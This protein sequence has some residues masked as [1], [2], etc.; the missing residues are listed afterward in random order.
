MRASAAPRREA[1]LRGPPPHGRGFEAR[2][3]TPALRRSSFLCSYEA[4]FRNR[5]AVAPPQ[6]LDQQLSAPVKPRSHGPDRHVQHHGG[7]RVVEF[8]QVT[9]D[10]D[11]AVP[12]RQSAQASAQMARFLVRGQ[13]R[14]RVLATDSLLDLIQRD[15]APQTPGL[16]PREIARDARTDTFSAPRG[17]RRT[18]QDLASAR[19]TPPGRCP[20]RAPAIRSWPGQIDTRTPDGGG[21]GSQR[22]PARLRARVRP[23]PGR[24]AQERLRRA[25]W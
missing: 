21:T 4:P 14:G 15:E 5:Q 18:G 23:A 6:T 24:T 3:A 9:E 1:A 19:E 16:V 10:D 22:L 20:P 25:P 17:W 7:L 11:L 8:L 2:A 12:R 13:R